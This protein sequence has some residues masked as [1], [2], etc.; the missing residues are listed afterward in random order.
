MRIKF[1]GCFFF[2][3]DIFEQNS[4]IFGSKLCTALCRLFFKVSEMTCIHLRV[5]RIV[6]F[7]VGLHWASAST[8][9]QHC[10]DASDT[11][12]I[13]NNGVTSEWVAT[14]FW[15]DS[16]E[17]RIA[18][19]VAVLTLMLGVNGALRFSLCMYFQLLLCYIT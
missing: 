13:E 6:Y 7:K 3:V 2:S 8:L 16:N 9:R 12:V 18:S 5:P 11:A 4:P 10:D 1:L 15:S 19:V 17:N 14:L